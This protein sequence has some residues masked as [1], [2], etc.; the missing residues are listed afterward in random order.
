VRV[1]PSSNAA[2]MNLNLHSQPS[3][4]EKTI[5]TINGTKPRILPVDFYDRD[6]ARVA[7]ELLGKVLRAKD[8]RVWRSGMILESEAYV[9][10]DPANHAFRGPNKRN[11]SMFKGPGT[12]YVYSIHRVHCVN[13][14]TQKGEAVLIRSLRP[15]RNVTLPTKG[16]GRLCR[17]LKITRDKH[18]GL[19]LTGNQIQILDHETHSSGKVSVSKRIGVTKGKE[20]LLRFLLA[21][22]DGI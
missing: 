17:A 10:N 6:T 14:V 22:K 13:A 19:S 3:S 8:G 15:F 18:D 21:E 5:L 2:S 7:R 4:E 9:N 11:Q 16:P 20:E 12:A 1:L